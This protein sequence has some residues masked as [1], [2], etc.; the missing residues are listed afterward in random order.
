AFTK[1]VA[2]TG[3]EMEALTAVAVSSL[4]V[5]DMCKSIDK[6]IE[7]SNIKLLSKTGGKSGDFK[8]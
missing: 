5:Y 8:R 4:T 6:S 7:I 2:K 3:I 1:T